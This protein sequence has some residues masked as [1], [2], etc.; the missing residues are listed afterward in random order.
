M[1]IGRTAVVALS[2]A[3]LGAGTLG[4]NAYVLTGEAKYRDWLLGYVDAWIERTA[5]NDGILPTKVGVIYAMT[6]QCEARHLIDTTSA[7]VVS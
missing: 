7:T 4:F 6:Q 5:A 1:N 2:V 3:V